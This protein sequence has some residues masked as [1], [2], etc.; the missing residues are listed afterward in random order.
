M[1]IILE[2]LMEIGQGLK[3]FGHILIIFVV[4]VCILSETC[5]T[6]AQA[7]AAAAPIAICI[8]ALGHIRI[9]QL[10]KRDQEQR[11]K[12]RQEL[13]VEMERRGI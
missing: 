4:S 6:T 10:E 7:A 2:I 1:K 11:K 8:V 3:D 5:H 12:R 9:N 13:C